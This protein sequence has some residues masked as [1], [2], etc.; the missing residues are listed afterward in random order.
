MP[1]HGRSAR[2]RSFLL[3]IFLPVLLCYLL[4]AYL[5]LPSFWRHYEH[6]KK[7]DGLPMV[8]TTAQGIPGDPIN[9]GMVGSQ[10][11]ILCAMRE[12]GWYAADPVTWKSS[13]EISGSVLLDQPYPRAP[14]SPLFYAGRAE[15][16]AFEKPVGKSADQRHHVRLWMVLKDGQEGRPVWLGAATFDRGVGF[17]RYTGAITH[18]I[19][20]DIDLDRNL[21]ES[22]LQAAG[23]I[24]ARYQVMGIGST[25]LGRNGGGDSYFTDGEVWVMRLVEGCKKTTVPPVVL[26][27]PPAVQFKDMIWNNI[28]EL[29]RNASK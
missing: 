1:L 22:S 27:S 10:K 2:L 23:M 24:T 21:I 8:T 13:I 11:D 14:V 3:R 7:L 25:L 4:L 16:L 19:A 12:A 26:P 20:P 17:S 28:A 15:D 18:H 6:Q 9:V 5:I 29:Y